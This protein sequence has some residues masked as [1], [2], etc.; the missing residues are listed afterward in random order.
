MNKGFERQRK[1]WGT[2]CWLDQLLVS[3]FLPIRAFL[4]AGIKVKQAGEV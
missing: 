3:T 2:I 1:S 4:L